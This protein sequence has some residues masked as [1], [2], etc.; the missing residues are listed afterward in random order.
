MGK[1]HG[2]VLVGNQSLGAAIERLHELF[3][4]E[5][6]ERGY[7]RRSKGETL[8]WVGPDG[9][10]TVLWEGESGWYCPDNHSQQADYDLP[11]NPSEW[12]TRGIT[13]YR[14][15]NYKMVIATSAGNIVW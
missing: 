8:M 9:L 11:E 7:E 14:Y 15:D 5:M 12:I 10:Q 2:L 1:N 4:L 3:L 6:Q 13:S